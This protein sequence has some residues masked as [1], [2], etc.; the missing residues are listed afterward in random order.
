MMLSWHHSVRQYVSGNLTDTGTIFMRYDTEKEGSLPS[1]RF[2]VV[3]DK[4]PP[5]SAQEE[6]G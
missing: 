5:M 4:Q 3:S 1:H 6:T 2:R